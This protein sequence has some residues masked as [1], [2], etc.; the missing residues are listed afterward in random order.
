MLRTWVNNAR[1]ASCHCLWGNFN[2]LLIHCR[3]CGAM[4]IGQDI[5]VS[6]EES[7]EGVHI[8]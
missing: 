7:E 5:W 1:H 8:Q 2:N 3:I 6:A 4:G